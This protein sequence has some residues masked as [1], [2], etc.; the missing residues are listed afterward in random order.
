M[1]FIGAFGDGNVT[2]SERTGRAGMRLLAPRG[3]AGA[4]LLFASIE[5]VGPALLGIAATGAGTALFQASMQNL[6]ADI[7]GPHER[8][9]I[10]G[11]YQSASA[12]AR[13]A[14]QSL[15]GTFYGLIHPSAPFLLG[16]ALMAPAAA[17][18]WWVRRHLPRPAAGEQTLQRRPAG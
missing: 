11:S 2:A 13:Y 17:L 1:R 18:L 6:L 15:S 14:G 9:R 8:G 3:T 10:M 16:A 5:H 4:W 12:L 7:A